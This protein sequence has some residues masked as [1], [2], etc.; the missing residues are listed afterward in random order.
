MGGCRWPFRAG[1][2]RG[3]NW[4]PNEK[5]H[6]CQPESSTK[7]PP[8]NIYIYT[9]I[10][11]NSHFVYK[12]VKWAHLDIAGV[13]KSIDDKTGSSMQFIGDYF[14]QLK[15]HLFGMLW[16][17]EPSKTCD[18]RPILAVCSDYI[19]PMNFP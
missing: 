18:V 6:V 1:G 13:A 12:D 7:N 11:F 17:M 5:K 19:I 9:S 14:V 8:C 16:L 3:L 15:W 10:Y 4:G 2:E